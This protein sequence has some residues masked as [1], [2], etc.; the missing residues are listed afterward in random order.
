M[1]NKDVREKSSATI[2]VVILA[3]IV[4][5]PLVLACG[6]AALF[7]VAVPSPEPMEIEYTDTI[8]GDEATVAPSDDP[9]PPDS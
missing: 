5:V 3:A 8:S 7:F 4:L 1:S 9:V 6:G 2:I